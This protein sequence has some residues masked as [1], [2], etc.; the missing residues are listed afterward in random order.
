MSEEGNIIRCNDCGGTF[1]K[2]D[3]Q[4]SCS[5]CFACLSCEMYICPVCRSEIVVK[6][7]QKREKKS[8]YGN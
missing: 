1:N 2:K 7:P 8:G 3:L 4:R 5:N 6:E